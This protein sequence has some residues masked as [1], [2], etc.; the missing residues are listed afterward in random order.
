MVD[1]VYSKKLNIGNIQEGMILPDSTQHPKLWFIDEE[2]IEQMR[3]YEDTTNKSAIKN[4]KIT[5]MF[6][7]FKWHKDNPEK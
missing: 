2:L 5:G 4:N 7:D 6:L 1:I 3:E